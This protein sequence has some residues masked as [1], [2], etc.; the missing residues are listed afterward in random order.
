MIIGL[1]I[2]GTSHVS[3]AEQ[4]QTNA[5]TSC[6]GKGLHNIRYQ[7]YFSIGTTSCGMGAV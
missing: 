6:M 2:C 3:K 5:T 7:H 1:M 4:R